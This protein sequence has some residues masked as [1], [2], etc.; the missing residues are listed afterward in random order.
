MATIQPVKVWQNG[1]NQE[2]TIFNLLLFNDNLSTQATFNYT[3][4]KL[5]QGDSINPLLQETLVN[6]SLI[7]SGADYQTWD[8]QTS[9]NQWAYDW[10]ATQL[11]LVITYY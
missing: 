9:A 7:I 10:A 1:V 6:G 11:N 8:S 5:T 2:A 3:L 4:C